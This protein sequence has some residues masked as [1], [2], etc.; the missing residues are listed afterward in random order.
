MDIEKREKLRSRL[1][2]ARHMPEF[3]RDFHDQKD[4]FKTIQSVME[5]KNPDTC[6]AVN[7]MQGQCYCIDVFLKFMAMHGYELRKVGHETFD[8]KATMEKQRELDDAVFKK[9]ME[10]QIGKP[11]GG[12]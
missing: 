3:M 7:W 4:L 5:T 11:P 6:G 1:R 2:A 9:W 8:L 12:A 10:E